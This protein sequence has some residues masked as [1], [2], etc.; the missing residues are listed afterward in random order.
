MQ[1]RWWWHILLIPALERQRQ[2][3]LCEFQVNLVYRMRFRPAA[4]TQRDP[5]LRKPKPKPNP[6]S[7]MVHFLFR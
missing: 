7:I 3:D 2:V 4:A 5:V 6:K 1:A